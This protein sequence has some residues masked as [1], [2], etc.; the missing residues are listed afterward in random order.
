[1]VSF[2]SQTCPSGPSLVL[3]R[4]KPERA[5]GCVPAA[6]PSFQPEGGSK[7]GARALIAEAGLLP[8][9][10]FSWIVPA[11]GSIP[12]GFCST[13]N[14]R[15]ALE[16]GR[17]KNNLCGIKRE[18]LSMALQFICIS[19]QETLVLTVPVTYLSC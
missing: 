7:Q 11:N 1:M 18:A 15:Q 13:N 16:G 14:P 2:L 17:K 6:C 12:S 8:E 3:G 9:A 5:G 10:R 19:K 4:R